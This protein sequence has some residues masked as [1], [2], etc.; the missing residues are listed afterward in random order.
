MYIKHIRKSIHKREASD[1]ERR[2]AFVYRKKTTIHN[3]KASNLEGRPLFAYIIN[4]TRFETEDK[5][6]G[7]K[8]RISGAMDKAGQSIAVEIH[9]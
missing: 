6:P 1:L 5:P 2:L 3:R 8:K 7:G 9:L 4:R